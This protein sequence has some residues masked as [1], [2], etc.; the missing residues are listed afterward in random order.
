MCYFLDYRGPR[1]P[2]LLS[3][4]TSAA[5]TGN[6]QLNRQAD[7]EHNKGEYSLWSDTNSFSMSFYLSTMNDR[8][9][10]IILWVIFKVK[11]LIFKEC[12]SKL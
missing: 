9:H 3:S 10:M 1:F 2:S 5:V 8:Y 12:R 4:S 6:A 11:I 7:S